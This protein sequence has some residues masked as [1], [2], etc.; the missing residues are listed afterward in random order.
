MLQFYNSLIDFIFYSIDLKWLDLVNSKRWGIWYFPNFLTKFFVWS[1]IL[2]TCFVKFL[3]LSN[4]NYQA[5]FFSQEVGSRSFPIVLFQW[6]WVMTWRKLKLLEYN[7]HYHQT[8]KPQNKTK[9]NKIIKQYNAS[10]HA[11]DLGLELAMFLFICLCMCMC[12]YLSPYDAVFP[13]F[14]IVV[15]MTIECIL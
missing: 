14:F 13:S 11:T 9:Q 2:I 8:I 1:L 12:V 5:H 7:N 6:L 4:R 3:E 10:T 15:N